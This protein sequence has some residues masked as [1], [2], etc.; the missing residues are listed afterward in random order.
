MPKLDV[1][2]FVQQ[3]FD[4]L[5]DPNDPHPPIGCIDNFLRKSKN[6]HIVN[7]FT[8]VLRHMKVHIHCSET[9]KIVKLVLNQYA[10]HPGEY[11]DT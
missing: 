8:F 7:T 10:S 4:I 11:Y 6:K 1:S 2:N 5:S 3:V 9:E